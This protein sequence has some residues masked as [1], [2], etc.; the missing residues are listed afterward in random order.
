[1]KVVIDSLKGIRV[2]EKRR[3]EYAQHKPTDLPSDAKEGDVL[4]VD[5]YKSILT[6][7]KRQKGKRCELLAENVWDANNKI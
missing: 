4:N 3:P 6:P 7:M 2:C 5:G 1:M